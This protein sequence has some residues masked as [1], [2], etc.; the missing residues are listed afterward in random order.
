MTNENLDEIAEDL[1]DYFYDRKKQELS[2]YLKSNSSVRKTMKLPL[3]GFAKLVSKT[4]RKER[5]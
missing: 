2:Y 5:E 1:L 3:Q 4:K